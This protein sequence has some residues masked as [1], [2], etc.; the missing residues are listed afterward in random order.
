MQSLDVILLRGVTGEQL[1]TGGETLQLGGPELTVTLKAEPVPIH[2]AT[3]ADTW[4]ISRELQGAVSVEQCLENFLCV[5][6]V[7]AL[8][9]GL[10]VTIPHEILHQLQARSRL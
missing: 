9:I 2:R 4:M 6:I 8:G 3:G 1:V 10:S 5:L 7:D